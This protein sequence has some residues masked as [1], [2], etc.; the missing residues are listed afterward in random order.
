MLAALRL[1]LQRWIGSLQ[2]GRR[3]RPAL[4]ADVPEAEATRSGRR[5]VGF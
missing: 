1:R 2:R 4:E 3:R 5:T